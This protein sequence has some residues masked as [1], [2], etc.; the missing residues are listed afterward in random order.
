MKNIHYFLVP[1]IL[2][3]IVILAALFQYPKAELHLLMNS[4][5]TVSGDWFLEKWT[6]VGGTVIPITI[7]LILLFHRYSRA[8]YLAVA[9]IPGFIISQLT[10]FVFNEPR[11][12]FYFHQHFPEIS[13]PVV[14]GVSMLS[15]PSF[16]SGHTANAFALFFALALIVKNK[17]LKVMFLVMAVL[18]GYSRI[19]LSQHFA[20]DVLAG[21]VIGIFSAWITYGLLLKTDRKWKKHS[22]REVFLKKKPDKHAVN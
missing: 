10:K 6:E 5:H 7:I 4:N 14:S 22:L 8:A 2:F 21:S 18:V 15:N 12:L 9:L 11:P 20:I 3:F 16:P 13:L 19:Y 17:W 1:Y